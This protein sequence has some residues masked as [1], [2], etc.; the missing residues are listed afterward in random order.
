[1]AGGDREKPIWEQE[2]VKRRLSGLSEKQRD[3]VIFLERLGPSSAE[4]IA[5]ILGVSR[6]TI[7]AYVS[8]INDEIEGLIV[9]DSGSQAYRSRLTELFP[10][11]AGGTVERLRSQIDGLR[12]NRDELV[13]RIR[14]LE[15]QLRSKV[16]EGTVE[17]IAQSNYSKGWRDAETKYAAALRNLNTANQQLALKLRK[18]ADLVG[19][20]I[21]VPQIKLELGG[22]PKQPAAIQPPLVRAP[23]RFGTAAERE[24]P[25]EEGLGWRFGKCE[26]LILKFLSMQ[27]DRY[28][29]RSQIGSITGYSPKGGG[30]NNSLSLLRRQRL[31]LQSGDT[32]TINKE[33]LSEA[34]E[35]SSDVQL[36]SLTDW[37]RS[38]YL[39]KAE[40]AIFAVLRERPHETYARINGTYP[41][42]AEETGYS[43][44]GGGFLNAISKLCTLGLA[45]KT[46]DGVR[47]NQNLLEWNQDA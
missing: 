13:K 41:K 8:D 29:T 32:F 35:I 22:P 26:K 19:G 36:G 18:V 39:G 11:Q 30:F 9:F 40:R 10:A 12:R 42:L 46:Q 14:Q 7:S 47:F 44:G 34:E 20:K 23:L 3:L 15:Q 17:K 2:I 4:K 38:P 1:M 33:R 21:E 6:N 27:P 16:D 5:P 43:P 24:K 31:I 45:E 28:F 37:L 25:A